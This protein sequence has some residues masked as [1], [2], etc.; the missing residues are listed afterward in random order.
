M[1]D[2]AAKKTF[3]SSVS[4]QESDIITMQ[5]WLLWKEEQKQSKFWIFYENI[6]I[7]KQIFFQNFINSEH[8]IGDIYKHLEAWWLCMM[9]AIWWL[10]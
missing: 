2:Y 7:A 3:S 9:E 5:T 4:L 1:K 8:Y 10:E 6:R